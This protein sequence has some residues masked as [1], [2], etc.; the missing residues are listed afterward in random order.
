MFGL[1]GKHC[2]HGGLCLRLAGHQFQLL[3]DQCGQIE[4]ASLVTRSARRLISHPNNVLSTRNYL[5]EDH[6]YPLL[7]FDE[8]KLLM[9]FLAR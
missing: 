1:Q 5:T 2:P 9:I 4:G 3:T 8:A 6:T 7:T